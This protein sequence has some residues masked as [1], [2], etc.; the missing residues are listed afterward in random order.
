MNRLLAVL[1]LQAFLLFQIP[2]P[3]GAAPDGPTLRALIVTCDRFLSQEETT[4][5]AQ[6]NARLMAEMLKRDARGYADIRTECDSIG[7]VDAFFSAARE[8]FSGA[9]EDDISLIYIST[10]GVYNP[11]RS[12]LTAELLLSDGQTEEGVTP[13]TL[14]AVLAEI[15]G[16]HVLL[17]DACHSG[18][19]IGKGL[20]DR[21]DAATLGADSKI[22]CSAGG[23]EDSWYWRSGDSGTLH[24]AGYFT[25]I[26]TRGCDPAAGF[27]ADSDADGTVTLRE[28]FLWLRGHY[29]VSTAQ[30]YP[31][32]DDGFAL[33]ACGEADQAR[34]LTDIEFEETVFAGRTD[35]LYF[36]FEL[37]SPMSIAYQLVYLRR[38]TWDFPNAAQVAE[39]EILQP[40]HY[41]RALTLHLADEDE[42]VSGYLMVQI[43]SLDGER[44]LLHES[45]LISVLPL[46]GDIALSVECPA[47]FRQGMGLEMPVTVRHDIPCVLTAAIQNIRGETV[48]YLAYEQQSRPQHLVPEGT[49]LYWDGLLSDGTPAPA[50]YYLVRVQ[51]EIGGD[52]YQAYSPLFRL[53]S[54]DSKG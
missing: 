27:P 10:H 45:R 6:E 4:P 50:G 3:A 8:T 49:C 18:A 29:A 1:F 54:E 25:S 17:V 31:E 37:G 32:R 53:M 13:Q 42:D 30:V 20:S 14:E 24:G 16:A 47:A 9:D 46:S 21:P 52:L 41:E 51:T 15:P 12:N 33:F 2:C 23:S 34:S 26:L 28:A 35:R 19:F 5:A 22:L 43:F 40:G 48:R 11:S 44:P 36:S 39:P 38:G 7:T